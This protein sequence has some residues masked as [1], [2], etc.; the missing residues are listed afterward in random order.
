[1]TIDF[2][3]QNLRGRSFK[4]QDL[5]GADFSDCDLR[6]VDFSW[7]DLT[8]AKFCRARM[9]KT[10]KANLIFFIL[11]ASFG[12]VVGVIL[13]TTGAQLV[14]TS[15][16]YMAAHSV[17]NVF[18]LGIS[19]TLLNVIAI[20]IAVYRDYFKLLLWFWMLNLLIIPIFALI[21]IKVEG[22]NYATIGGSIGK[23]IGDSQSTVTISIFSVLAVIAIIAVVGVLARVVAGIISVACGVFIFGNI[24]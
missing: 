23:L 22:S 18:I 6:G 2:K 24:L 12:I 4:H 21:N 8:R 19:Y 11:Q 17:E 13:Y 20:I 10:W 9:G 1:M 14:A 3:G 15:T 5:A 16:Y 7:A